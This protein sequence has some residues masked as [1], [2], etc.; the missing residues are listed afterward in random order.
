MVNRKRVQWLWR[1]EGLR[2]PSRGMKRHRL[3]TSTVP[4]DRLRAE[5]PN[6]VWAMDFLFDATSDGRVT[7]HENDSGKRHRRDSRRASG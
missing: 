6:Q 5:R 7:R 3:G 2:V 4:A 1:D